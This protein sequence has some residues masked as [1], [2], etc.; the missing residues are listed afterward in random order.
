MFLNFSPN[1]TGAD[2]WQPDGGDP[3]AAL[4]QPSIFGQRVDDCST[5]STTALI[6]KSPSPLRTKRPDNVGQIPKTWAPVLAAICWYL[7]TDKIYICGDI[8]FGQ[9]HLL[10]NLKK[11]LIEKT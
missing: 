6:N 7:T 1:V 9:P 3:V 2:M 10:T 5:S 4:S 8:Y 11:Y